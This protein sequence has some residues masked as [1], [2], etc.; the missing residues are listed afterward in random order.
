MPSSLGGIANLCVGVVGLA[1]CVSQPRPPEATIFFASGADLQS[2]NPL[3]AVHPLAKQVQKHV[4]FMTLATYDSAI[5][6]VPRLATWRW[7]AK[8]TVLTFYLRDDVT[9]HDGVPTTAA[10][11]VWT[12]ERAR[13][14]A[15]AYPR[16]RDLS[17]VADAVMIDSLTVELRLIE[18]GAA[19]VSYPR[20]DS[21]LQ[22]AD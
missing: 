8:R 18:A 12:L 17:A 1:A 6:P 3:V 5:R 20:Q 13:D 7:N 14:P 9:W 4:L 11:V 22:P 21:N 15:V 2:I 16:A 10:D 19:R